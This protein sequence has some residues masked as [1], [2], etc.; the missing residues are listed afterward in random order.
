MS[1]LAIGSAIM[2][3]FAVVVAIYVH[4]TTKEEKPNN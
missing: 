3:V 1:S 2:A 4:F